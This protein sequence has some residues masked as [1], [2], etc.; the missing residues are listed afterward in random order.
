MDFAGLIVAAVLA[1]ILFGGLGLA[2]YLF[3]MVTTQR[4]QQEVSRE[5]MLRLQETVEAL[6]LRLQ[7]AS[8]DAVA[9]IEARQQK[10]EELLARVDNLPKTEKAPRRKT[11]S[12]T[13]EAP[14]IADEKMNER[15]RDAQEILRLAEEGVDGTE[16]ARR[17]GISRAEVELMLEMHAIRR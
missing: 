8:N 2:W 16:I 5:D 3:R 7:E 13:A 6:I 15:E 12:K 9:E 17:I 4:S 1:V 11:S 10:L 14:K